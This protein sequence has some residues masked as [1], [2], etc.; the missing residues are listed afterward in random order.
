MRV[1]ALEVDDLESIRYIPKEGEELVNL[2]EELEFYSFIKKIKEVDE[3]KINTKND[4]KIIKNIND[5]KIDGECAIYLEL[6]GENY[7]TSN[8]YGMGVYNDKICY[9]IPY[10]ILKQNP[11]FLSENIKYTYDV[12]KVITSLRWHNIEINNI[13]FDTMIAA[14][15]LN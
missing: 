7:H 10:E 1:R 8:I 14:Y 9:Y 12:K 6:D 11:K 15:L 2:Y 4:V 5:I 3:H 13:T